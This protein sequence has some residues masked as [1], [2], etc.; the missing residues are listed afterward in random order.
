LVAV[1]V[2]VAVILLFV[3]GMVAILVHGRIAQRV[4]ERAREDDLPGVLEIS[5]RTLSQLLR[6]VRLHLKG[7]LP[8][9]GQGPTDGSAG[10]DTTGEGTGG[11]AA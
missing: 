8:D 1:I 6:V 7:L 4:V 3:L 5:G 2:L 9:G 11:A 10:T